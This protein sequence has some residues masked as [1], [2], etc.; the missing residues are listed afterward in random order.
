[1]RDKQ[2][3]TVNLIVKTII[4]YLIVIPSTGSSQRNKNF[5]RKKR[6]PCSQ[7]NFE[8]YLCVKKDNCGNDGYTVD[9]AVDSS[10]VRTSVSF[11][12]NTFNPD[13]ESAEYR[14]NS[15]SD[16][17][18]RKSSFY[19]KPE[20]ILRDVV[21]VQHLCRQYRSYGYYC[22]D[23]GECGDDGY[24]IDDSIS[25]GVA[26]RSIDSFSTKLSCN[27]VPKS[28][29]SSLSSMVCCRNSSYFGLQEPPGIGC[30]Y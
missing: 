8:G 21:E 10:E 7:F 14:C 9:D 17:C 18:C 22:I 11:L 28:G 4:V 27:L 1:M 6:V 16:I 3:Q 13:F 5:G 12:R 30:H 24:T 19:G 20:P 2:S 23:E 26:V 29:R 25:G 15:R